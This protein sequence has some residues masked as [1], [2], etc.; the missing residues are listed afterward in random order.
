MF[1]VFV[2]CFFV[3]QLYDTS[4]KLNK[5]KGVKLLYNVLAMC[6]K[7]FVTGSVC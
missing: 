6:G 3:Y 1:F 4:G 7:R 2:F 5:E